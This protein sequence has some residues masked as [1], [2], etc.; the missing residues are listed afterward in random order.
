M[1][2]AV[3][4]CIMNCVVSSAYVDWQLVLHGVRDVQFIAQIRKMCNFH[5]SRYFILLQNG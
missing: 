5:A 3:L 1:M 4:I 2:A